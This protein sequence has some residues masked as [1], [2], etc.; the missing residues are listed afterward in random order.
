MDPKK[1]LV[2]D[3]EKYMVELLAMSMKNY[4]YQCVAA[5]NGEEALALAEAEQPAIILLDLMLPGIDGIETCRRLKQN[6]QTVRIPVIMLTAKSEETDKIMGLGIGAD[7][8]VTKPFGVGELFARIGVALRRMEQTP[9]SATEATSEYVTVGDIRID[10]D[11]RKVFVEEELIHL[12]L[13]EY[14]LLLM[15]AEH[16]GR[17][18]ERDAMCDELST[19]NKRCTGR[20]IDVHIRN[21]RR[22]LFDEG[23]STQH[24]ETV[25]GVGY[26]M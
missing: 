20:T 9:A 16:P 24:I 3:D 25:R 10:R 12:T 4:G 19:K 7:D 5:Y 21:L 1:I 2:V 18:V 26:R 11:G 17:V 22:K 14:R 15:M 6:P 13:S 8:Y 23:A